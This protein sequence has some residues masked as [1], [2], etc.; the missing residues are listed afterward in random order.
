VSVT[1]RT[2]Q[3]PPVSR[4]MNLVAEYPNVTHVMA[5]LAG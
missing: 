5:S 4:A 1:L 3:V 2:W